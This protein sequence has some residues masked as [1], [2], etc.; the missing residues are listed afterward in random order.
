MKIKQPPKT[1]NLELDPAESDFRSIPKPEIETCFIYEYARELTKR[2][3]RILSLF[4]QWQAGWSAGKKTPQFSKARE[5]YKEFRKIMTACFPDFPLIN[6]DWFPDTPWQKLDV[7]VRCR[8]VEELNKG[9]QHYWNS[10]PS[11]KLSIQ[12]F[13][14]EKRNEMAWGEWRYVPQPFREE[15]ISQTERGT[16]AINWHYPDTQL[17]RA[18]AEWLSEQRKDREQ[19]GLTEIKYKQKGRGGFRDQLNWLGAL[20]VMEHYPRKQLVEY[21]KTRLKI[22]APP[23]YH[24]PDFYEGAKKARKLVDSMLRMVGRN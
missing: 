18:F 22:N 23:Y 5:A 21:P 7:K 15:D 20:R 2:C 6:E 1:E 9:P 14:F 16:F 4:A 10:L 19:R 24:L 13:K 12:T 3:P 11:H 17:T 8:L